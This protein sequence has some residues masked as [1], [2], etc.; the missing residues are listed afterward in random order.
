MARDRLV[1]VRGEAAVRIIFDDPEF[2]FQVLRLLGS[3]ASGDA[4][5]GEVLSTAARIAPGDFGSW[6]A[7]WLATARRVHQVADGCLER[8]HVVGARE[9]YLR[10]A[11]YRAAEFY[12]HGDPADPRIRE[13]SA[14]PGPASGR[15]W[16]CS[17]V[18][19]DRRRGGPGA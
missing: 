5:A 16:P 18:M 13:L 8:S 19:P 2:D 9:A 10:A 1:F 17:V 14:R 4:E 3:A 6:T 12:L 11:N 15:L 7:Q